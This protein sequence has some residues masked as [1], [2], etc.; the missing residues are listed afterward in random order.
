MRASVAWW[1]FVREGGMTPEAFVRA[2]ADAGYEGVELAPPEHW[3]LIAAHGL[4]VAAFGGHG[5]L[6][7]GLNRRENHTR[8]AAEIE[9][10]S[11]RAAQLGNERGGPNLICFSGNRGGLDDDAGAEATAEGLRRVAKTAENAGVTLVLELLNSKINHPDYQCDRTAWGV[12]VC[13]MV[14]SPAVRLLYDVYHMQIMEGDL[15]RTIQTHHPFFGHYHIAGNPGRHEPDDTQEINHPAVYRA[16]RDT[17]YTG[18]IGAEFIPTGDPVA[19]LRNARV[20]MG[21]R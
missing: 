14:S 5:P 21:R 9:A 17:G 13:E 19:A 4:A 2:A 10:N 6:T 18:W 7:D 11:A 12:R 16:I 1:C 15:I 8:I 20:D 3:P